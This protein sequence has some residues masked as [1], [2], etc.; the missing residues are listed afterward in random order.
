[1]T[2]YRLPC[3]YKSGSP[4]SADRSSSASPQSPVA[5]LDRL[6]TGV[7]DPFQTNPLSFPPDLV[8]HC[9]VYRPWYPVRILVNLPSN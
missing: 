9:N 5:S 8:N 1:M 4:P 2:R 3:K 7:V 6:W